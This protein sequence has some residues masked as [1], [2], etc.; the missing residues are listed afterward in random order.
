MKKVT[1][2]KVENVYKKW[3]EKTLIMVNFPMLMQ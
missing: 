2:E 3:I 1:L